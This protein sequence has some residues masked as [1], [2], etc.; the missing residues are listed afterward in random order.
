MKVPVETLEGKIRLTVQPG[1]S[2]GQTLRLRGTQD[3]VQELRHIGLRH[4][5][6]EIHL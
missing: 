1:T 3:F 4:G 6:S 5:K 2:S